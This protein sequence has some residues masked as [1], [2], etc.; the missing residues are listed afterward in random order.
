MQKTDNK[1]NENNNN[2]DINALFEKLI[3]NKARKL[4]N[5]EKL[6][7]KIVSKL[8]KEISR[9]YAKKDFVAKILL[10]RED[11]RLQ[12]IGVCKKI[13]TTS[14]IDNL[15]YLISMP[16]IYVLII[17][18]L[19][20]HVLLELYHQICFRLY[21]IQRVRAR[22]YFV[23]DRRYLPYLN[24]FEKFNCFYCSYFNC[25]VSYAK[26]IG[27]RTEKY[28]CPIK[29][30]RNLKDQHSSYDDFVDYDDGEALRKK[31]SQLRDS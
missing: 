28:W 14:F 27:G 22:E 16:F 10:K 9:L 1:K 8:D 25:F 26:E 11:L 18:V 6:K 15:R 23:F 4:K 2:K 7:K 20:L 31:W 29:H 19:F 12:K 21:G 17:P 13:I 24:W 5:V 3:V 30:S